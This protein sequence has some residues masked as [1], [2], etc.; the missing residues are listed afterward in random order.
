MKSLNSKCEKIKISHK[1][2]KLKKFYIEKYLT[3]EK[4][5]HA[6]VLST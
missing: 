5:N 2:K 3:S 1:I 4:Y 6:Y